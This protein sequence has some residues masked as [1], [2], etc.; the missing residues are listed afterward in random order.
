MVGQPLP[1]SGRP[2]SKS[3]PQH[4][5][6]GAHHVSFASREDLGHDIDDADL[7][8]HDARSGPVVPRHYVALQPHRS[9][10]SHHPYR[11]HKVQNRVT[12]ILKR[13]SST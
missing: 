11:L 12:F 4:L 6:E 5:E 1:A 10:R 9:Q 7:A 2:S 13:C 8:G 3:L